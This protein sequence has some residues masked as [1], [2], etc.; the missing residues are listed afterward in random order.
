MELK[1]EFKRILVISDLQEPC[2]HRDAYDFLKAVKKKYK[3]DL[4]VQIGDYCDFGTLSNF[5]ID[6][7]YVSPKKELSLVKKATHKWQKL[8]PKMYITMGNHEMRLYRKALKAG[9]P[10]QVLRPFNEIVGADNN[11]HFVEKLKVNWKKPHKRMFFVH[12]GSEAKKQG[13][14][15]LRQHAHAVHG[16]LHANFWIKWNSTA[17][18]L[19]FDM[20]VG[21]LIDDNAPVFKYNKQ[22]S[23]R[24][25]LGCG[26]ILNGL[27]LLVP[28]FLHKN[29]RW[30][31][32]L[33]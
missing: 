25:I 27:P 21:C 4:V 30:I 15:A 24:P 11:W 17:D 6:P 33:K 26:L 7:D 10:V 22:Q 9:F 1:K 2:A 32:K 12:T 8:F 19:F 3:P 16:H 5:D 23:A 28:M 18:A 20:N 31:R 29:G 13:G 14:I